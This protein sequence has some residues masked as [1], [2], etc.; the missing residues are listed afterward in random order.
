MESEAGRRLRLLGLSKIWA[1]PV[2]DPSREAGDRRGWQ[3]EF[4]HDKV[5]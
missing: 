5:S 2:E 4:R 1:Q 3:P